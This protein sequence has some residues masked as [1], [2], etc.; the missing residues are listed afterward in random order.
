MESQTNQNMRYPPHLKAK[1]PIIN[2]PL[3]NTDE[4]IFKFFSIEEITSPRK[5]ASC[6]FCEKK[7]P[8]TQG[9]TVYSAFTSCLKF[10][11]QTHPGQFDTYL[12]MLARN[13]KPDTKTK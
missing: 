9:S 2:L 1:T 10:H 5:Q 8:F 11:L 4:S 7:I 6:N 12:G 3:Y 13:M